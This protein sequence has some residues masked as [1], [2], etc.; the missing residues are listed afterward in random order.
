MN[1]SEHESGHGRCDFC[2]IREAKH[3]INGGLWWICDIC[4][5]LEMNFTPHRGEEE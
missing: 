5:D 2:Q 3:T 1:E 4:M